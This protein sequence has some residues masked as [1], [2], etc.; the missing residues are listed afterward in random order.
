MAKLRR[1]LLK[2]LRG[3]EKLDLVSKYARILIELGKRDPEIR[4]LA[5]RIVSSCKGKDY[6][7]EAET[8]HRW[9]QDNVRYIK[10]PLGVERFATANRTLQERAGDCDDSSITLSALLESIGHETRL[11]FIDGDLSGKFTHVISQVKVG[12]TWY[13]METTKKV[14]FGW[15][16]KFTISHII[17]QNSV[18]EEDMGKLDDVFGTDIGDLGGRG[19]GGGGG[20]GGSRGG[21][22]RGGGGSRSSPS[23][24]SPSRSVVSRF[25]SVA[26]SAAAGARAA[27]SRVQAVR[28]AAGQRARGIISATA[29]NTRNKIAQVAA[30]A[31]Q[32]RLALAK[33]AQEQRN[34]AAEK[35]KARIQLIQ[36]A[37]LDMPRKAA[38]IAAQVAKAKQEQERI[39]K[40]EEAVEN[41]IDRR[42]ETQEQEV[43]NR[44]PPEEVEREELP[45]PVQP[46]EPEEIE[47]G[48][49]PEI[50]FEEE[51][52]VEFEEPDD[53]EGLGETA[54]QK[55]ERRKKRAIYLRARAKPKGTWIDQITG[56]A[57]KLGMLGIGVWAGVSIIGKLIERR[58]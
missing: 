48:E 35:A 1:I 57:T 19:G 31:Q 4:E 6:R 46:S 26:R 16:P 11:I 58:K 22:S 7:C 38:L 42:E 53:L 10:D 55:A 20:G 8:L 23:R 32:T 30:K 12:D 45:E 47:P 18:G 39:A 2:G 9:V 44:A 51:S 24:S 34:R 27:V 17:D 21:G 40:T 5:V 25:V 33:R 15:A 56:T 43:I 36:K 28:Q 41:S 29:G 52:E 13:W 50:E 3:G 54:K 14:P 37:K 49:E